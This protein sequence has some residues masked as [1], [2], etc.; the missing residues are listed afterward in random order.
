MVTIVI[1]EFRGE[2]LNVRLLSDA[3]LQVSDYDQ[4]CDC[5][6]QLQLCRLI[7]AKYSSL[8]TN[9]IWGNCN[10][11][12]PYTSLFQ[13]IILGSWIFSLIVNISLFLALSVKGNACGWMNEEWMP[14][15]YFLYWSAMA[16]M[17]GLYSRIVYTLWFKRD[18]D[19]Q[20]AA[21]QRVS[22][23]NQ[24]QYGNSFL[25]INLRKGAGKNSKYFF[26]SHLMYVK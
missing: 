8:C 13:A 12:E 20:L 7:R 16:I 18:R 3:R 25:L 26:F 24:A 23:N 9:H 2:N 21:Q 19:N 5:T 6:V 10:S 4:L 22:I 14:K 11:Y 1:G 15:A 17:A